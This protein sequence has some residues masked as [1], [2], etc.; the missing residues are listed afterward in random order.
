MQVGAFSSADTANGLVAKLRS[1]GYKAFVSPVSRSGKA[2]YRVR[3]GP[4]AER[5][6]AVS[7]VDSLKAKGLPATVVAND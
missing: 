4:V 1:S 6:A 7:M 5:T 2:L 3:V